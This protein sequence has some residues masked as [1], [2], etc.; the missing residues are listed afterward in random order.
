ME[1]N[2]KLRNQFLRKGAM[3][4]NYLAEG[5]ATSDTNLFVIVTQKVQ[6][7]RKDNGDQRAGA[8]RR[9]E[10]L[11]YFYNDTSKLVLRSVLLECRINRTEKL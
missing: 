8:L 9:G 5:F 1:N 2:H 7:T 6:H 3:G 11:Q 4:T 10:A